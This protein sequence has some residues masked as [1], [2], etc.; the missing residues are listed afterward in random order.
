MLQGSAAEPSRG[1]VI[2]VETPVNHAGQQTRSGSGKGGRQ[3]LRALLRRQRH[4]VDGEELLVV[5]RIEI[6][7]KS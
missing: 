5:G 6:L 7:A 3:S 1:E 2:A 4:Q